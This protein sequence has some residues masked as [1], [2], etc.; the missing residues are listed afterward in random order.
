MILNTLPI[1]FH[2]VLYIFDYNITLKIVQD[3]VAIVDSVLNWPAEEVAQDG[4]L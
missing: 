2:R 3:V 1:V 4:P